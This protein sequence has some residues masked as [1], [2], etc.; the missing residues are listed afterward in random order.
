MALRHTIANLA[1]ARLRTDC[2]QRPTEISFFSLGRYALLKMA[3][4]RSTR[5]GLSSVHYKVIARNYDSKWGYEHIIVQIGSIHKW[6]FQSK[7]NKLI[8][9]F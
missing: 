7:K 3:G 8:L 2:A 5:D 6:H 9:H 1:S 4:K